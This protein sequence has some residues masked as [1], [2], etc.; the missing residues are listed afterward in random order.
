MRLVVVVRGVGCV[1]AVAMIAA[2]CGGGQAGANRA[3]ISAGARVVGDSGCEACHRIG[4]EGNDGPGPTLTTVGAHLSSKAIARAL[5]DPRE[6][7]PSYGGPG[8]LPRNQFNAVVAY[9]ASLRA[10]R[11][12][13]AVPG[14][15]TYTQKPLSPKALCSPRYF[16]TIVAIAG[17]SDASKR[18]KHTLAQVKQRLRR[19]CRAH[20]QPSP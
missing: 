10:P 20:G 15:P 5:D 12:A 11:D 6:P 19:F 17:G 14:A 16:A 9:L 13:I 7:M 4:D 8:G 1:V 18:V 3:L 2:G